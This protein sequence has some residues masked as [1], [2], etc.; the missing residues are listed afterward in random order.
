MQSRRGHLVVHVPVPLRPVHLTPL[1]ILI[2]AARLPPHVTEL[3]LHGPPQ[4]LLQ[5]A[6]LRRLLQLRVARRQPRA[7]R[8]HRLLL[9]LELALQRVHHQRLRITPF[10]AGLRNGAALHRRHRQR[11][12]AARRR[13]PPRNATAAAVCVLFPVCVR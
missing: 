11:R 10:V 5:Q 3:A 8:R 7:Q 6:V 2:T 4:R 12:R 1:P 13:Q 9:R